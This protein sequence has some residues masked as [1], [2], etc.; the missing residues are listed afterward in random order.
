MAVRSLAE[1]MLTATYH[2]PPA[3]VKAVVTKAVFF[4]IYATGDLW[5]SRLVRCTSW[6]STIWAVVRI[7]KMC[8]R[9]KAF[10]GVLQFEMRRMR[11]W[12]GQSSDQDPW[13]KY[14]QS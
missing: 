13:V 8:R 9:Q 6:D 5:D 4:S 3:T 14:L 7:R 12:V 2:D 11:S 10:H 1:V